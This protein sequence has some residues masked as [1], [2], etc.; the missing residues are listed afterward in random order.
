MLS[1]PALD[2]QQRWDRIY[3]QAQSFVY[4]ATGVGSAQPVLEEFLATAPTWTLQTLGP[5]GDGYLPHL[6]QAPGHN[7]AKTW[8]ARVRNREKVRLR[9]GE[10]GPIRSALYAEM[11]EAAHSIGGNVVLVTLPGLTPRHDTVR[12]ASQFKVPILRFDEPKAAPELYLA[13]DR[14]DRLHLNHSGALAFSKALAKRFSDFAARSNAFGT[15][16]R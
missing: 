13:K 14:W 1:N 2:R 9:K 4:W 5:L 10:L 7:I 11:L 8:P 12:A 15:E 3:A 16:D 6:G